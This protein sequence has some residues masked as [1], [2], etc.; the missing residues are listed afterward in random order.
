MPSQAFLS[1]RDAS[2][3]LRAAMT[4]RGQRSPPR[5]GHADAFEGS[6]ENRIDSGSDE[7]DDLLATMQQQWVEVECLLRVPTL[8]TEEA[9]Q[10][11]RSRVHKSLDFQATLDR[12]TKSSGVLKG[13]I[14]QA[15]LAEVDGLGG[16]THHSL[17]LGVTDA[18]WAELADGSDLLRKLVRIKVQDDNDLK[19]ANGA[20]ESCN[21]F[22]ANL[23]VYTRRKGASE[24]EIVERHLVF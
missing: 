24:V 13:T 18:A 7:L 8:R 23:R 22:F 3:T 12:L 4:A 10:D 20:L 19:A 15:L 5:K 2:K 21:E 17:G 11:A 9:L 16:P 14:F 1:Y 6:V